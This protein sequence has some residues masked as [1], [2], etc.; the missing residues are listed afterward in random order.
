MIAQVMGGLEFDNKVRVISTMSGGAFGGK[1]GNVHLLAGADGGQGRRA[2]GQAGAD[3]RADLLADAI[4]AGD[5]PADAAG[6]GRVRQ[7]GGDPPGLGDRARCGRDRTSSP[8]ARRSPRSTP[9]PTSWSTRNRHGSTR[10]RPAGCAAPAPVSASSR[11]RPRWTCSRN[12]P[13]VDPLDL[14]L[15]NYAETEP[16]T[17]NEWSSKSLRECYQVAAERIG[18]FDRDPAIGSMREGRDLIG[19]GMTTS[20]YKTLQMP[21]VAKVILQPDGRAIAQTATH[22]IGPG[23]RDGDDHDRRRWSWPAHRRG[24]A[25]VRGQRAS[26]MAA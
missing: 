12:R 8:R 19:F 20:I 14:R 3:A 16:D 11:S 17:G 5:P 6:R 13:A 24:D 1:A 22:E 26:F 25:R 18:W 15:R 23:H 7:A 2:S 4:Q 21:A 10:A 9:A